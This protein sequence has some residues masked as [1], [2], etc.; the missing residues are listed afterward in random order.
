MLDPTN[1]QAT[2]GTGPDYLGFI[3]YPGS[4]RYVGENADES[5]FRMVPPEIA[6]VG[7]FVNETTDKLLELAGRLDLQVIQLH[8]NEKPDYCAA[9]RLA[10]YRVIKA[11]GIETEHDFDSLFRYAP[12]CDY[13]LF[14]SGSD[15][16]GGSG[17]RFNWDYLRQYQE[18][19]PFF[20]SG[21]ISPGDTGTIREIKHPDFFAVDINS[22][23]ETRPGVKDIEMV[24]S[25]I[26]EIKDKK[27]EVFG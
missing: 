3:F 4:K 8:G 1:I 12:V 25:F 5:L 10:G 26:E 20:L 22:R 18:K 7:V 16:Y 21:G 13:F 15:M 24:R 27:H 6:K 19:V 14:D 17:I 9:I 2:A 23:F 11:F